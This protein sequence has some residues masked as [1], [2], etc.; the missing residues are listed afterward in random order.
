MP[1]ECSWIRMKMLMTIN[2]WQGFPHHYKPWKWVFFLNSIDLLVWWCR[3]TGRVL[4]A[5]SPVGRLHTLTSSASYTA[6]QLPRAKENRGTMEPEDLPVAAFLV[7]EI[8]FNSFIHFPTFA[9]TILWP[10]MVFNLTVY[11]IFYVGK[12]VYSRYWDGDKRNSFFDP[13]V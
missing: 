10:L 3:D 5:P 1:D 6:L 12:K 11:S 13:S 7:T 4:A 2:L 9:R 8:Y